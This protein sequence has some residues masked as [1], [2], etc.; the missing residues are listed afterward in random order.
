MIIS[1]K[2]MELRKQNGW[3]QEELAF[4]L[5]V[6]RQSVSKWE[7]AT[8][9]PDMGKII[10]LSDLFGVSTDYLLKDNLQKEEA[11][12]AID[13][14]GDDE[15]PILVSME[16]ANTFMEL[17][18]GSTKKA[19]IAVAGYL[20]SVAVLVFIMGLQEGKIIPISENMAGGIGVALMLLGIACSTAYFVM[21][22]LKL[23]PYEY[24]EKENF[25]LAYGVEGVVRKRM[26]ENEGVYRVSIMMGVFLCIVAAVPLMIAVA[27]DSTDATYVF[28]TAVL[29]ILIAI[30]VY[31]FVSGSMK[32]DCYQILLQEG[33]YSKE[34]KL[35][36]KSTERFSGIYWCLITAVYLGF[37]FYTM[38][39]DLTW[40]IWPCAGVAFAGIRGI[41]YAIKGRA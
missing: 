31:L 21:N 28:C 19:G 13:Q 30:A 41:V 9:I 6:S 8:S 36:N 25:R 3:S 23:E 10:K 26:A 7:S 11:P 20:I 5:G 1:E 32:K 22:G 33:D 12:I 2:I 24:L 14:A 34:K 38:R 27:L 15:T 16:E 17:K 37:S 40:I 39:W 4:Q 29:L 18:T 35:E